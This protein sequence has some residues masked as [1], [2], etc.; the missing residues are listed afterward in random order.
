[1][2]RPCIGC[3]GSKKRLLSTL[4]ADH[5][6]DRTIDSGSVVG[7][8]EPVDRMIVIVT[9]YKHRFSGSTASRPSVRPRWT[10]RLAAVEAGG[11]AGR[12]W[13]GS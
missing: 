8:S 12:P 6:S 7:C 3:P 1:M 5:G 13:S 4:G 10:D 11:L 2:Y 9:F